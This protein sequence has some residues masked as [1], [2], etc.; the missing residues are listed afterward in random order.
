MAMK[1][2]TFSFVA[3]SNRKAEVFVVFEENLTTG[4]RWY[5]DAHDHPYLTLVSYEHLP[6]QNVTTAGD[7]LVGGA[8]KAAFHF[9]YNP[10][11]FGEDFSLHFTYMRP[12]AP[13]DSTFE[14]DL[15]LYG[16]QTVKSLRAAL[17]RVVKS[18]PDSPS[19]VFLGKKEVKVFTDPKDCEFL[20]SI[21][22]PIQ[23]K[24]S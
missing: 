5:C 2:L 16:T 4:Y 21:I 24:N 10:K 13:K 18:S 12:F 19:N 23:Q 22:N 9:R 3:S 1:P 14:Y 7:V 6:A 20:S 17:K 8:G 15:K 11:R